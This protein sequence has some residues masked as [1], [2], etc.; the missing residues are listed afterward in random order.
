[1]TSDN[2]LYNDNETKKNDRIKII[3]YINLCAL[4]TVK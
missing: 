2:R 3:R 4:R 1:M